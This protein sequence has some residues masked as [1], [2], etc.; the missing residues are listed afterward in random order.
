MPKGHRALMA[1]LLCSINTFE[2]TIKSDFHALVKCFQQVHLNLARLNYVMIPL[3]PKE[4]EANEHQ[5][6]IRPISLSNCSFKMRNALSFQGKT[7]QD[8]RKIMKIVARLLRRWCP[9]YEQQ[10]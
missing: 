8:R 2:K 10:D 5:E 4:P 7:R 3:I 6:K 9:L 1:S